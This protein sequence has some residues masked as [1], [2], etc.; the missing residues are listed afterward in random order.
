MEDFKVADNA[1][2][3]GSDISGVKGD[4]VSYPDGNGSGLTCDAD[5][6]E[7][8]EISA[9]I[10]V[11]GATEAS[12]NGA[13]DRGSCEDITKLET[14]FEALINGRYRDVYKRRTEGII[15]KRL[16]SGKARPEV[17]SGSDVKLSDT[18]ASESIAPATEKNASFAAY[19]EE[20]SGAVKSNAV[21]YEAA[22]EKNKNR[23][24][25]NGLAGSCGIVTKINVSALDGDGVLSI[26]R[27]VGSGEKIS[28]K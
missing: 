2:H 17:L 28:F 18:G 8:T 20:K 22:R 7:K 16:R 12:D 3:G 27:R 19:S 25:E 9:E 10:D 6:S 26:L 15:R 14:E 23:P 24:L 4:A 11:T 13:D 21:S 1:V 5:T